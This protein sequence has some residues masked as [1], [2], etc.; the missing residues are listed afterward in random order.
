MI[1]GEADAA[2]APDAANV[3]AAI[4]GGVQAGDFDVPVHE[5][6][7][8]DSDIVVHC[9]SCNLEMKA[10]ALVCL[11][12]GF[13]V[14]DGAKV[15]TRVLEP[16]EKPTLSRALTGT[17]V[18]AVA[19]AGGASADVLSRRPTGVAQALRSREDERRDSAFLDIYLPL[20]FIVAGMFLYALAAIQNEV[21]PGIAA[22]DIG[23][24]I[25]IVVPLLLGTL[26]L[27]ARVLGINYGS[28]GIGLL[29]LTG[30]A[31]GPMALADLLGAYIL[32]ATLGAGFLFVMFLR[33]V[34]VGIPLAKMFDLGLGEALLTLVFIIAIRV[35][36]ELVV[37]GVL[38][39][40]L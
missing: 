21:T 36:F 38:M 16:M 6:V 28:L 8:D 12:C 33:I 40:M 31:M 5:E 2:A 24:Y 27:C 25:A 14:R 23:L 32:G 37:I 19:G 29:K 3:G 13:N 11:N 4:G 7:P 39:T 1:P 15:K 20:I 18:P 10:S 9:P 30:L 17:P 22:R 26:F 34:I 35:F